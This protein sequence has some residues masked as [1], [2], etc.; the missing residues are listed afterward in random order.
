MKKHERYEFVMENDKTIS[1]TGDSP[2][3]VFNAFTEGSLGATPKTKAR[4][5][6]EQHGIETEVPDVNDKP[7]FYDGFFGI[8]QQNG[9]GTWKWY[10][11][12]ANDD[13]WRYDPV[14]NDFVRRVGA[15]RGPRSPEAIEKLRANIEKSH[16][17]RR[18]NPELAKAIAA[19]AGRA[20]AGKK[21]TSVK[22]SKFE[23]TDEEREK[24]AER[25]KNM[26]DARLKKL[27][28]MTDEEKEK[29]R[30]K[31]SEFMKAFHARRREQGLEYKGRKKDIENGQQQ[32]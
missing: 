6:F 11:G 12:L 25:A 14:K 3:Q 21:R 10:D 26:R 18:A 30:I 28:E 31:R 17:A 1:F 23:I 8:L 27:S 2:E 22:R 15:G 16:E 5:C 13:Y 32:G 7:A 20:S 29:R 24:R 4:L 19:K 9:V